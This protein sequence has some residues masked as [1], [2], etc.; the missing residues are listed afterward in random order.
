MSFCLNARRLPSVVTSLSHFHGHR[1]EAMFR[2]LDAALDTM[3]RRR[4][5]RRT[6]SFEEIY[7]KVYICFH[8]DAQDRAQVKQ[9]YVACV[10][11][12]ARVSSS[13]A[14]Y[15]RVSRM[16]SD[17]F[18]FVINTVTRDGVERR[19]LRHGVPLVVAVHCAVVLQARRACLRALKHWESCTC[20][21]PPSMAATER[22]GVTFQRLCAS[23]TGSSG[24]ATKRQRV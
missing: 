24:P 4:D 15:V 10:A 22:G 20:W 13:L 7:R 14:D 8:G 17:V 1:H 9:Y 21:A 3:A 6:L 12:N 2:Q 19:A 16:L 18:L 23:A 5:L 11:R